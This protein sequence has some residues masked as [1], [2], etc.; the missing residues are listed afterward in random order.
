MRN[1]FC[2][3]Y[4]FHSKFGK[5]YFGIT[6]KDI[7]EYYGSGTE[8][9]KHLSLPKNRIAKRELLM[10]SD[11][12]DLVRLF[13][14]KYSKEN[15]IVNNSEYLNLI[16][17]AGP[18]VDFKYE[19]EIDFG[20]IVSLPENKMGS[21]RKVTL[22]EKWLKQTY[23][24]EVGTE[25]IAR[26]LDMTVSDVKVARG[27]A[28]GLESESIVNYSSLSSGSFEEMEHKESLDYYRDSFDDLFETIPKREAEVLKLYYGWDGTEYTFE[29][30]AE[31]F[32]L[33][34]FR[35]QQIKRKAL[36]RLRHSSRI[37]ILRNFDEVPEDFI[38]LN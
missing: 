33:T 29:D 18:S 26:A 24:R 11:N 31:K 34:S 13:C 21:I 2:N 28:K 15:D 32:D 16:E 14:K 7:F 8:W 27:Y 23:H 17:E 9:K 38:S 12:Y 1:T 37:K 30:I 25:E 10:S 20:P 5:R 6:T 36:G 19:E 4:L 22:T 35:I 3:V